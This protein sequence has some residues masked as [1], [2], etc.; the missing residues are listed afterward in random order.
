MF[1]TIDIKVRPI[2]IAYIVD[3]NNTEQV[4][5]AIRLS[6][7]LWGGVYFPII[8]LYKRMPATW[9]ENPFEVPLAKNVILGYIE[10]FDP[11]ILVQFSKEI[12]NYLTDVGLEI[13]K[14]EEI[15]QLLDEEKHLSPK[16][17]LGIFELLDDIFEEHF[18]YKSKYPLKV[19]IPKIPNQLSL[20]WVSLFGEIPSKLYPILEKYYF[21]P[22]EVEAMDFQLDK[23][24]E[25][26]SGNVLFPRRITQRRLKN[27]NRS[28]FRRDASIYF[29]DA[30]KMEDIVDFWN[31]RAMGKQVIPV[32]KQ[33]RDD[34]Q[35]NKI[36][37]TFL[38]E[39]RR[40]WPHNPKVCDYASIIR[41][42]N[43]TM[44][45][46]QEYAKT[47]KI[48]H[49]P[50]D[51]SNNPF[52]S[53]QHLYP[54]LWDDWARDKD[55]AV[56]D[57]L[58]GEEEN[59]IEINDTKE[60]KF[61]FKALLPKFAQEYSY[62]SEPRCANDVSFRFYAS[63]E[64]LAEVL[65]KSFGENFVDAISGLTSFRGDWRVGRSGLIKIVKDNFQE[66][67]DI[68]AA[69][70]IIFAWLADLGWKPK[71][72]PPG[73]LAKQIQKRF[74]GELSVLRNEKLL[75]LL[76]HMN[77]GLVKQDGS[78]VNENK[79][80]QERDLPVG[81]VKNRLGASTTKNGFYDYLLS[82]EIFKLGLRIQCPNC[83]RNSWFSLED[84][85]NSF[86]CPKCQNVFLAI[87]NLDNAIWCYKTAGPFSVPNYADGAYA[88][89]L[90]LDFFCNHNIN[91]IRKTPVLSFIGEGV[92]KKTIEADF[93]MFWGES[94]Y[95]EKSDG[96]MF[97]ECKTYGKFEK[98]DFERMH[99][100][101]K[102]FPGAVLVFS[103][104]RKSLT[105]KEVA[106]ITRIAKTGRKYWKAERP[107]N[108]VLILTGTELLSYPG[109]PNC[110]EDSIKKKFDYMRGL[111]SV[112]DATQ[113]IYLNLPSW[114]TDWHEKWEKK[115]Q[116]WK[117]RQA[118]ISKPTNA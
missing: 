87:G 75:S 82:K 50:N 28:G 100:L 107:I 60:L 2:R 77:G 88:V 9:K 83:L 56:P 10:A 29:L 71:L 16:F 93:A 63:E 65:P 48:E 66:T 32:P 37:I 51:P 47:L 79:I 95:G 19:V 14:P 52:F 58:Y 109:P 117:V 91:T 23:L 67:R 59:S 3:P 118:V 97:G 101:A 96:I 21:E 57:D 35:L 81:E 13:T 64:Y 74:E 12:P 62:H 38:K 15:W 102:T 54:R 24:H 55:G 110:W 49:L 112:C 108:P 94:T 26:M 4:R 30:T 78:P 1:G 22:L 68:P 103:T 76:E 86:T 69:E 40:P 20:F 80:T 46:V 45:E 44:E 5:E 27:F 7:T 11:D 84:V 85:G 111:L 17:G 99:Y 113:Q 70:N 41:A 73:L 61:H 98:K 106:G 36:V 31:L 116:R 33:L 53:L 114:Q 104:L 92:N 90:T 18:K 115:N 8:P 6:S 39:H 42:R 34:P 25:I 89:L 105:T 72:S 43:C